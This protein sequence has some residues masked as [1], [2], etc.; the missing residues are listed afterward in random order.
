MK[1]YELH[2]YLKGVWKIDSMFD[3][4]EIAIEEAK[5]VEES[6]RYSGI[7]VIEEVYDQ[8]KNRTATR[9]IFRGGLTGQPTKERKVVK[10]K[11]VA[12]GPHFGTGKE[13]VPRAAAPAREKANSL[14]GRIIILAVCIIVGLLAL[15][16]LQYLAR[17]V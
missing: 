7:R 16:G 2:T 4:P 12:S 3:D 14:V 1:T 9:T 13:P 15:F 8:D 6:R 10:S 17:L 11:Q 5:R